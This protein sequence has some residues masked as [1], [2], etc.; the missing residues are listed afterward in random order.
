MKVLYEMFFF[1]NSFTLTDPLNIFTIT[2]PGGIVYVSSSSTLEN[3]LPASYSIVIGW[4]NQ[5]KTI[6]IKI[7]DANSTCDP[8][9]DSFKDYCARHEFQDD[10]ENACGVGSNDGRCK[11]RPFK[12]SSAMSHVSSIYSTCTPD[13]VTW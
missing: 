5:V 6:K 7:I 2:Q 8:M 3:S 12:A 11:W 1:P 9:L 10:C 13:I 4:K